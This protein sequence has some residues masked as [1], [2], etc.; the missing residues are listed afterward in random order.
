MSR[1]SQAR[2]C[3]TAR[4]S[5]RAGRAT[6]RWRWRGWRDVEAELADDLLALPARSATPVLEEYDAVIAAGAPVRR[7]AA[8]RQ[9][10]AH[11]M[12]ATGVAEDRAVV[13]AIDEVG[14]LGTRGLDVVEDLPAQLVPG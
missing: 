11:P 10:D 4:N 7:I 14:R 5:A 6:R 9:A 8:R 13:V 12:P 2:A 3:C 1:S